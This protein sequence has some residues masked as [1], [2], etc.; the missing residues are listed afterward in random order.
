MWM[1]KIKVAGL[2]NSDGQPL[3]V[4]HLKIVAQKL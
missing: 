1:V 2:Y 3:I 4:D